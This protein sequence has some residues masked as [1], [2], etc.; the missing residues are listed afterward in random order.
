M[1]VRW[2]S[3]RGA[4]RTNQRSGKLD[5]HFTT[6]PTFLSSPHDQVIVVICRCGSA[7]CTS[8]IETGR[9][10]LRYCVTPSAIRWVG[11]NGDETETEEQRLEHKP[12]AQHI[13]GRKKAA[14]CSNF[15][16]FRSAKKTRRT[17]RDW[18]ASP[19]HMLRF[20]RCIIIEAKQRISFLRAEGDDRELPNLP[21]ITACHV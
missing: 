21:H 9:S 15:D 3:P 5:L 2:D 10:F 12:R 19:A 7:S 1:R 20:H 13:R 16:P 4:Q 6:L 8:A 11:L 14:L 17:T 18:S